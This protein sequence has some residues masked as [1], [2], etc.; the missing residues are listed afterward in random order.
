[1]AD[2][3]RQIIIVNM[4][5][6]FPIGRLCAH[7]AHASVAVLLDQGEWIDNIFTINTDTD[8]DLRF[9]MKEAFTKV[10]CKCWGDEAILSLEEDA[11]KLGL[12]VSVIE[13][14]GYKTAMA[15]GPASP[16]KL[17]YFKNLPLL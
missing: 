6:P 13:E 12:P 11:K 15:I 8:Y 4:E 3:V 1:M 9:W 14:E 16:D 10:V 5:T 7:A 2:V 17:T